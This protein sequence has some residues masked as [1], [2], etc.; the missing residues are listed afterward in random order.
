MVSMK[1]KPLTDMEAEIAS[2]SLWFHWRKLYIYI[3]CL[4]DEEAIT[5]KTWETMNGS[6]MALKAMLP[7]EGE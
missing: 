5:Q 1:D 2:D 3:D 4:G 6:L 7:G